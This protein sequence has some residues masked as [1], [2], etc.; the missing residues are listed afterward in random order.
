MVRISAALLWLLLISGCDSSVSSGELNGLKIG[1][2]KEQ[3]AEALASQGVSRIEPLPDIEVSVS[4]QNPEDVTKLNE[5]QG[6]CISDNKGYSL[7]FKAI[8]GSPEIH[9]SSNSADPDRQGIEKSSSTNETKKIVREIIT[10]N[11]AVT[12]YSCALE[13]RKVTTASID[14]NA[15]ERYS[16][17]MYYN[18]G[19]YS[20]TTL[21][22]KNGKLEEI[23][24]HWRPFELP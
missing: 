19:S 10:S 2:T 11:E 24:Y 21:N 8:N 6:I 9:Y 12:A 1:S 13:A 7:N 3:V 16:R 15:M 22:F 4:S 17:F 18:P 14:L 23:E 20:T 5:S